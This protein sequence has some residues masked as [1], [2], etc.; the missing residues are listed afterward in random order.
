MTDGQFL[1]KLLKNY[2]ILQNLVTDFEFCAY[3]EF[4]EFLRKSGGL[5]DNC[6]LCSATHK[7]RTTLAYTRASYM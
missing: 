1:V 2:A 4:H 7:Q 3:C 5:T 6:A